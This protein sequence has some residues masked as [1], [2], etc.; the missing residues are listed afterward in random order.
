LDL[1]K[2]LRLLKEAPGRASAIERD[3]QTRLR[4]QM[5]SPH[6]T[7]VT[8]ADGAE[9]TRRVTGKPGARVATTGPT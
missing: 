9:E 5:D 4:S 2:E 3:F 6:E 8:V 7:T 1:R